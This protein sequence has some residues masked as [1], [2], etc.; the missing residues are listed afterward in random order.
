MNWRAK[1][2]FRPTS[3]NQSHIIKADAAACFSYYVWQGSQ[4]YVKVRCNREGCDGLSDE[5]VVDRSGLQ[6]LV[7]DVNTVCPV[8]CQPLLAE[9][10]FAR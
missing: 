7:V 6:Y 5:V 9:I 3:E 8:C 4:L 1:F 2:H 10:H